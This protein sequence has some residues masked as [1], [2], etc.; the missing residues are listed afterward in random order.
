M[1]LQIGVGL[2]DHSE[3][4][5]GGCELG[6]GGGVEGIREGHLVHARVRQRLAHVLVADT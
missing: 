2:F 4:C 5:H 1:G 3:L 6:Y